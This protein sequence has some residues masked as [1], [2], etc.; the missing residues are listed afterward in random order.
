MREL[1]QSMPEEY[2]IKYSA[3]S[4]SG[5]LL[6]EGKIRA[7]NKIS[8]FDAQ[9]SFENHLQKTL[10]GFHKLVV[11]ECYCANIFGELFKKYGGSRVDPFAFDT[12]K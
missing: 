6:K 7:K 5:T 8:E 4:Q 2:I 3:F 10:T 12:F 1:L 9:A 11:H